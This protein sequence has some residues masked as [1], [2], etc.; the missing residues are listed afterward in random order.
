M[1]RINTLPTENVPS[2]TKKLFDQVHA[3]LGRVPNLMQTLGHS[4]SALRGY[5]SLNESL[6]HGTLTAKDRERIAL[7][8]A[9][10]NGCD[11]CLAAHSAIGKMVGLNP[12][13]IAESRNGY[14]SD[15]KADA[16]LRF[17][18]RVL[19][20]NGQIDDSDLEQFRAEGY[21]DGDVAEVIAH[22]SLSVL[23]NFFNNVAKTEV[24]FPEVEPIA[25]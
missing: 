16:L 20:S 21:S 14:A 24:D 15:S 4:P 19:A 6:S 11:Y 17:V 5:L 7:A 10:H 13:Q 2:D 1:S 22:I 3:K 18:Q 8:V 12:N 23:T 9:E 25:A